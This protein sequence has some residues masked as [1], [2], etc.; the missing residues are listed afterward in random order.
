MSGSEA[1]CTIAYTLFRSSPKP[2]AVPSLNQ[3]SNS[4]ATSPRYSFLS[5]LS[6]SQT[7]ISIVPSRSARERKM[8][9]SKVASF[10]PNSGF[11][12]RL[13]TGVWC[14][15]F[16]KETTTKLG[17]NGMR[18]YFTE[19]RVW[20]AYGSQELCLLREQRS[21]QPRT[22]RRSRTTG[23][24]PGEGMRAF[25]PLPRPPETRVGKRAAV[26]RARPIFRAFLG[27]GG[28]MESLWDERTTQQVRHAAPRN[29]RQK[30]KP[31]I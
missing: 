25:L 30:G 22:C 24:S 16:N 29:V 1:S 28:N 3:S 13:M 5:M 14:L 11:A 2:K 9:K 20:L 4:S 15:V 7:T 23:C 17:R 10:K 31:E 19:R 18:C 6:L 26:L 12:L 21:L 8:G 27:T